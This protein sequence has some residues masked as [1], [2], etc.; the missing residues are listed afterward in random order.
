MSKR[1]VCFIITIL[2]IVSC[3]ACSKK[4]EEP[5]KTGTIDVDYTSGV[6]LKEKLGV[7]DTVEGE[8]ISESGLT[9]VYV[10]AKV[11][12]PEV[13]RVDVIEALPRVYTDEEV[14]SFYESHKEDWDWTYALSGKPYDGG[15]P[16][17]NKARDTGG[18]YDDYEYWIIHDI[19][20]E[21]EV[22]DYRHF[23]VSYGIDTVTGGPEFLL[24]FE[25]FR[26][27]IR[28]NQVDF[29][30]QPLVNNKAADCTISLEEAI[31][32]ADKDVKAL[33]P[34]Y[35]LTWYGQTP[36][37]DIGIPGVSS[38]KAG[39]YYSLKYSRNLNGVSVN[40]SSTNVEC[41]NDYGHTAG[42]GVVSV[43]VDDTGVIAFSYRKGLSGND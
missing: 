9:R 42:I 1:F 6:L 14:L 3:M 16:T 26:D 30:S 33:L 19:E 32:Y 27:Y 35:E 34:D 29:E 36:V 39:Q 37:S 20:S 24:T 40:V 7:P 18:K 15:V 38:M 17:I 31:E 13:S 28:G 12:V 11:V 25:Y 8:Y 2:L 5:D 23:Y 10:D 4:S 21:E 22:E 41:S 43:V